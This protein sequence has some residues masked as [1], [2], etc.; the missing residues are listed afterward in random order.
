MHTADSSFSG[1]FAQKCVLYMS[2]CKRKVYN[3]QSTCSALLGAVAFGHILWIHYKRPESLGYS[4]RQ[5][6]NRIGD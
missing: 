3:I 6:I 5:F 2:S 4:Y 1:M